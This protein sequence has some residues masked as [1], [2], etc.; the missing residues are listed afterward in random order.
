MRLII[1]FIASS[2]SSGF[3]VDKSVNTQESEQSRSR[4]SPHEHSKLEQYI[5]SDS[6]M[7]KPDATAPY[8]VPPGQTE[9]RHPPPLPPEFQGKQHVQK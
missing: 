8:L 4:T 2:V 7:Q 5:L 1:L 3:A 9:A 6:K